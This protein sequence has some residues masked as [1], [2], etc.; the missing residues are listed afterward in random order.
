MSSAFQTR[1]RD[2]R[3][4]TRLAVGVVV[5][6]V[7]TVGILPAVFRHTGDGGRLQWLPSVPGAVTLL[8]AYEW[9]AQQLSRVRVLHSVFELSASFWWS[10]LD[11]PDT[12][13]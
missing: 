6:Y 12:T 2:R 1:I 4:L 10:L 5:G 8:Q 7:V 9:P 3:F 13:A 11:P